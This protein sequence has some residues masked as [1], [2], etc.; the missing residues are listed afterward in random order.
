MVQNIPLAVVSRGMVR[1][2]SKALVVQGEGLIVLAF[3][4]E[5]ICAAAKSI[6][7]PRTRAHD[8]SL[9]IRRECSVRRCSGP[10]EAEQMCK[11]VAEMGGSGPDAL[12]EVHESLSIGF[13]VNRALRIEHM[14]KPSLKGWEEVRG[15]G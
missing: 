14:M 6:D 5:S 15:L 1:I 13:Q 12:R 4:I 9:T 7:L 10:A 2:N 8:S 11:T 3:A